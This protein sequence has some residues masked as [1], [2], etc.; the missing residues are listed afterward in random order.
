MGAHEYPHPR[1]A[2]GCGACFDL[3][4]KSLALPCLLVHG[5]AA[6]LAWV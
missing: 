5:A 3:A 1:Q 4:L 2:L 6:A